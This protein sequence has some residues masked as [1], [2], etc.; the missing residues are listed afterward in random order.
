MAFTILAFVFGLFFYAACSAA[1]T[2]E[3]MASSLWWLALLPLALFHASAGFMATLGGD[4]QLAG[5]TR[6]VALYGAASLASTFLT[7]CIAVWCANAI[8]L[9]LAYA[10]AVVIT[11]ASVL[12]GLGGLVFALRMS[13]WQSPRVPPRHSLEN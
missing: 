7:I 2:L 12:A 10:T 13:G 5:K 6:T 4:G 11:V 9:R 8:P 1:L 3:A